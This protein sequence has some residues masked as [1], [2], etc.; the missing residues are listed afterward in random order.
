MRDIRRHC[1]RQPGARGLVNTG[2]TDRVCL[3]LART[4][5]ALVIRKNDP[6][7]APSLSNLR[8]GV[9]PPRDNLSNSRRFHAR[10]ILYDWHSRHH[11]LNCGTNS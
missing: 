7:P 5:F 9:Q 10:V 6:R 3:D 1:H 8:E 2:F 11:P 4:K